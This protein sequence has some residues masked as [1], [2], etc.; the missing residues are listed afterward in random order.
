MLDF[1]LVPAP[2]LAGY[3]QDFDGVSLKAVENLAIVSAALPLG[4]EDAAEKAIASAFGIGLPG[5][6]Q[7][8]ASQDET[9]ALVR[10]AID[11]IFI[12]FERATPDAEP[13]IAGLLK[14]SVYSTD[15]TDVWAAL[16]ISGPKSRT[17][18]ERICPIDLHPQ[19]FTEGAAARTVMEHLG[20]IIVRTNV[21][22]FLLLSASSSAQSFLHAIE[23]SIQNTA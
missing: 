16:E 11:Q 14:G 5:V 21:D 1:E 2:P 6:G 13:F 20:A 9:A 19:V 15:Q 3:H 17:A 22:T 7:S 10:L 4:Q 23:T 18:L 12:L 8:T